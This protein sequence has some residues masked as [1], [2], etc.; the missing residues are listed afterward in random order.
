MD[1]HRH[2]KK[3]KHLF[4]YLMKINDFTHDKQLAKWLYTSTS[5]I[6]RVR[7]DQIILSP[8]LILRIYDKTGLSIEEIRKMVQ[9]DVKW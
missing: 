6:S 9:E 7:H 1:K 5:I 2:L 8:R 4:R 3:E